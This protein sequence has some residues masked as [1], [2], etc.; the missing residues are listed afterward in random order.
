[1]PRKLWLLGLLVSLGILLTPTIFAQSGNGYDL[2][3]VSLTQS[4]GGGYA[5]ASLPTIKSYGTGYQLA[6]KAQELDPDCKYVFLP[7]VVKK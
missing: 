1:M 4:A 6:I 5:L 7:V 2:Q 3:S